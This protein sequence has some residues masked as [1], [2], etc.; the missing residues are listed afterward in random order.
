MSTVL[1]NGKYRVAYKDGPEN[2]FCISGRARKVWTS[3]TKTKQ[4]RQ[5][6]TSHSYFWLVLICAGP[7]M[8]EFCNI[9]PLSDI[10]DNVEENETTFNDTVIENIAQYS[11]ASGEFI[12]C[13]ITRDRKGIEKFGHPTYNCYLDDGGTGSKQKLVLAARKRKKAKA[14]S[15]LISTNQYNLNKDAFIA[16]LKS[17]LVGTRYDAVFTYT[18]PPV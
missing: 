2:I 1:K 14:S 6:W 8:C 16:K 3:P 9:N 4:K 13:R 12:K 10:N 11:P 5:N 7:C 18:P 17:N 15:Y